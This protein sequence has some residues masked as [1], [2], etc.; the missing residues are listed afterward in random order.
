MMVTSALRFGAFIF[1]L[2]AFLLFALL[3]RELVRGCSTWLSL[4]WQWIPSCGCRDYD[5]LSFFFLPEA[6][7]LQLVLHFLALVLRRQFGMRSLL[8]ARLLLELCQFYESLCSGFWMIW[9]MGVSVP[10]TMLAYMM[11]KCKKKKRLPRIISRL[12]LYNYREMYTRRGST[13][14]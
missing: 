5:I 10:P 8:A 7:S 6:A 9:R 4:A 12:R 13:L 2:P 14:Y 11:W 1:L 3:L